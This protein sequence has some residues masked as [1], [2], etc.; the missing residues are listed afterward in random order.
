MKNLVVVFIGMIGVFLPGWGQEQPA[1]LSS[2]LL[3][4]ISF[5][6]EKTVFWL[7]QTQILPFRVSLPFS[8]TKVFS[9]ELYPSGV[10][11]VLKPPQILAGESIGY[12]RFRTFQ[13]G[14]VK[15]DLHGEAQIQIDILKSSTEWILEKTR[16]QITA[17]AQGAYVWGKITIGVEQ[18]VD[19]LISEKP[20]VK[21]QLPNGQM[22]SPSSQEQIDEGP[23]QYNV[24]QLDVDPFPTGLLEIVACTECSQS[25]LKSEP[26]QLIVTCPVPE[27]TLAGECEDH[28]LD[29]RPEY[30]GA[31]RQN[32]GFQA[33]A[34][35]QEFVL[36]YGAYP[37]WGLEVNVSETGYYQMM[38]VARGDYA[39]GAFPTIG[40]YKGPL[41]RAL[42]SVK[43]VHHQWQRLPL[44][45]PVELE[46]GKHQLTVFFMNDFALPE[47]GDRNLFLDRYELIRIPAQEFLAN[48]KSSAEKKV[49][50]ALHQNKI[51]IGFDVPL[52]NQIITGVLT[53]QAHCWWY[54]DAESHAPYVTLVINGSPAFTQQSPDPFFMIDKSQLKPGEN[55]LELK[56][57]LP[58]G[59]SCSSAIQ[60][61]FMLEEDPL[62]YAPRKYYRFHVM[63]DSWSENMDKLLIWDRNLEWWHRIALISAQTDV[64]A[65]TIPDSVSG[66]FELNLEARGNDFKGYPKVQ[67]ALKKGADQPLETIG[68]IEALNWWGPYKVG[69]VQL[70]EGPKQLVFSYLN[71]LCEENVGD[72]N[73]WLKAIQ[74]FEVLPKEDRYA[75]RVL[76]EYP[77]QQHQAY[78]ADLVIVKASDDQGVVHSDLYIDGL[79]QKIYTGTPNGKGRMLYP[80]VLRNL[81]PGTHKLFVRVHDPSGNIGE[82]EEITFQVLAEAPAQKLP[83]A[84][85]I[86]LLNRLGYGPDPDELIAILTQGETA[87]LNAR[88]DQSFDNPSDQAIWDHVMLLFID[89]SGEYNVIHRALRHMLMTRNP[90]RARF[91]LWLQ[92]HF[93]TWIKK[94]EP[95]P[96]WLE[97]LRFARLGVA[98]FSDLLMNS[99]MS[100]AML[101]YLDQQTSVAK[102][103]NENYA[104]E[105]MELHTLGV[106]G[107]YKQEDVTSLAVLLNGWTVADEANKQGRGFPL[108]KMFHFDPRL[109]DGTAQNVFGMHFEKA[110]PAERF[111]RIRVALEMLV[112]HPSTAHFIAKKFVQQ[113][114]SSPADELLV[115]EMAHVFMETGGDMKKMF[116]A[117]VQHP[118]FWEAPPRVTTPLEFCTRVLRA[119]RFHEG[120][121][122]GECLS[123]TATQLFDRSTPD[124]YP[125]GNED[126]ANSNTMLQ[127]WR[128]VKKAE[129]ALIEQ[130][131]WE[132]RTV[133]KSGDLT[134]WK[135]KVIDA[136]AIRVT[137]FPLSE[138]SNRSALELVDTAIKSNEPYAALLAQLPEFHLR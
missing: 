133:P 2:T 73:L 61:V 20:Q 126:Y 104:R 6:T 113:Y 102:Q 62:S 15:L 21:L 69:Q 24:F 137:G 107:G 70:E 94:T 92:N 25:S 118:K 87:W 18:F 14:S 47:L 106:H 78:Q 81:V 83:Y 130:I 117:L 55:T 89:D 49:L 90:V 77:P 97:Y 110:S 43:L 101:F 109:N 82:S 67:V 58:S 1:D 135:Q 12:I 119:G 127:K 13:E 131:P 91:V 10:L 28:V 57:C 138:A 99:S 116:H 98:P 63:G 5:Y 66:K 19:P 76:I 34:S 60:K 134:E 71:D 51:R 80:L 86:H 85:A 120:W 108:E 46:P 125:E 37:A 88:L 16:P 72:R 50:T 8:E 40:L 103:L 128:F 4:K 36:N 39:G 93:S 31:G 129:W 11:E 59:E 45:Y 56:A 114:V 65:L 132:W 123:N 53:I 7:G 3:P 26:L 44:G 27:N 96:K 33:E 121:I 64:V 9:Y 95:A 30:M 136:I 54:K 38:M 75:P 112:S 111:D 17:P 29:S 41:D 52:E 100:P 42:T 84:R 23:I 22:L 115:S 122:V 35:H 105:I 79:P 48:T 32:V 68:T 124:G 74:L